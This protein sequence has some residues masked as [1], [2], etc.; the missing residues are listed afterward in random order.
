MVPRNEIT[1]CVWFFEFLQARSLSVIASYFGLEQDLVTGVPNCSRNKQY[2]SMRSWNRTNWDS[3]QEIRECKA[4]SKQTPIFNLPKTDRFA[5]TV[6]SEHWFS[7]KKLYAVCF[8]STEG[9]TLS[10]KILYVNIMLSL[11]QKQ[12]QKAF[13]TSAN[14]KC[15]ARLLCKILNI[16]LRYSLLWSRAP[17]L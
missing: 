16:I 13:G 15:Y 10:V 17:T 7:S 12:R 5:V 6:H 14:T 1:H 8:P 3:Y 4:Q 9:T 2:L 11:S